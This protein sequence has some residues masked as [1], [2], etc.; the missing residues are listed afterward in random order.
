MNEQPV[1]KKRGLG[2]ASPETVRRVSSL[3]GKK[4]KGGG[5]KKQ[6]VSQDQ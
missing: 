6:N 2:S 3:G 1:K 4:S 5:R